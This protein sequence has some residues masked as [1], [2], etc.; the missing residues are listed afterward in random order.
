MEETPAKASTP[1]TPE[2]T[3]LSSDSLPEQH[4]MAYWSIRRRKLAAIGGLCLLLA[5]LLSS[6]LCLAYRERA[7]E[8]G[9]VDG[10]GR[11][12]EAFVKGA[13]ADGA[14]GLAPLGQRDRLT[15]VEVFLQSEGP[16]LLTWLSQAPAYEARVE[17]GLMRIQLFLTM[18]VL[19][20][21]MM[22]TLPVL[23]VVLAAEPLARRP[24]LSILLVYAVTAAALG[25]AVYFT[26]PNQYTRHLRLDKAPHSSPLGF[27]HAEQLQR[28]A[29]PGAMLPE[30]VQVAIETVGRERREFAV[31]WL[32]VSAAGLVLPLGAFALWLGRGFAAR[33][34]QRRRA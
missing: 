24:L 8:H 2:G 32:K 5:A 25:F 14:F 28:A 20:V 27:Y 29:S 6:P 34:R 22:T 17:A 23:G 13:L 16:W 31:R 33:F 9:F 3:S 18:G 19:G 7:Q 1:T 11:S 21:M 15:G 26:V 4:A 10:N 30:R 12:A